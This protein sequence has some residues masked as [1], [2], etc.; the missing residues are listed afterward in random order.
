MN[1]PAPLISLFL[2]DHDFIFGEPIDEAQSPIKDVAVDPPSPDS[3]RSPR[4]QM[5]S[6]LPTPSY[7]TTSFPQDQYPVSAPAPLFSSTSDE[8]TSHSRSNSR[9]NADSG[10]NNTGFVPIQPSYPYQESGY[11]SLNG[12]LATAPPAI[13]DKSAERLKAIE[14]RNRRESGMLMVNMMAAQRDASAGRRQSSM[15]SLR[16][17]GE[18]S[19][20]Y[21]E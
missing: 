3:I 20:F 4:R 17:V 12:A 19:T 10:L 14:K 6:D 16:R 5:F 9:A 2:T 13:Q 7:N 1:I 15:S 8:N 11:S 21:H 18:E